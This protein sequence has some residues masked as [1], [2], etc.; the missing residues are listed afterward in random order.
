MPH[1]NLIRWIKK[2]VFMQVTRRSLTF[3]QRKTPFGMSRDTEKTNDR[4]INSDYLWNSFSKA[5]NEQILAAQ[6][7]SDR[8]TSKIAPLASSLMLSLMLLIILSGCSPVLDFLTPSFL[9]SD[10][11]SALNDQELT[12]QVDPAQAHQSDSALNQENHVINTS[13]SLEQPFSPSELITQRNLKRSQGHRHEIA[14]LFKTNSGGSFISIDKTGQVL[15]WADTNKT[16]QLLQLPEDSTLL[17]FHPPSWTIATVGGQQGHIKVFPNADLNNPYQFDRLKIKVNS[18]DFSKE[19]ESILI[20]GADS[21]VYR[22]RFIE[23]VNAKTKSQREKTFE[24]YVEHGSVVSV[25]RSHPEGRIF[26]SGDWLGRLLVTLLFDADRFGGRYDKNLFEGR[27]FSADQ[28]VVKSSGRNG[29]AG[30]SQLECSQDGKFLYIADESGLIEAW[31]VRGFTQR[32]VLQAHRG[33]VLDLS[34]SPTSTRVASLGR[35]GRVVLSELSQDELNKYSLKEIREVP[36][37]NAR[38]LLF[39]SESQIAV[40]FADGHIEFIR[41]DERIG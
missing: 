16:Y 31:Q 6:A 34:I 39:F 35:D 9:K 3:I 7:T 11:S 19:G 20:A 4:S 24:R 2:L 18:I 29:P 36:L 28:K 8:T 27:I 40:G 10:N 33:A 41:V 38:R 23:Q 13:L 30:I 22:W 12:S 5:T 26:F 37:L 1:K 15:L 14:A 32:A 21:R 25:V 17:A